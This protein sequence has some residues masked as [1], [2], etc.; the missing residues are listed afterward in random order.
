MMFCE[1]ETGNAFIFIRFRTVAPLNTSDI[2][3]INRNGVFD[4]I[5]LLWTISG[6]AFKGWFVDSEIN[7][8][9]LKL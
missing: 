9:F 6:F 8:D 3:E 4:V 7:E 2:F 1:D 5:V